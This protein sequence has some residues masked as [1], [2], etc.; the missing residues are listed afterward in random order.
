MR[1]GK[2]NKALKAKPKEERRMEKA[3]KNAKVNK[4]NG[5]EYHWDHPC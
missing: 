1:V 2:K 3:E 5:L 4:N